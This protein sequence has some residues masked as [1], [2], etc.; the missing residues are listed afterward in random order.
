MTPSSF[1]I[2]DYVE[3]IGNFLLLDDRGQPAGRGSIYGV[4][5]GYDENH[6]FAIGRDEAYNIAYDHDPDAK[7]TWTS[8]RYLKHANILDRLSEI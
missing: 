8:P 3:V 1:K 6:L 2:G 7:W 4:I 5:N